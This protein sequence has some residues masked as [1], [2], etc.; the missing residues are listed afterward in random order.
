MYW[1]LVIVQFILFTAFL[2][3]KYLVSVKCEL[4]FLFEGGSE[5]ICCFL[6]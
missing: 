1:K 3:W 2:T 4:V 5:T 6:F